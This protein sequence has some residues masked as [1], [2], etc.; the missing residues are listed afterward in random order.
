MLAH[1]KRPLLVVVAAL[2]VPA[3]AALVALR[4]NR[5]PSSSMEPSFATGSLLVSNRFAYA[6]GGA[7]ARGDAIVFFYPCQPGVEFAKR[8]V[9]VEGDVVSV[10]EAGFATVNGVRETA[11]RGEPWHE[12][13]PGCTPVRF[14]HDGYE[15]LHC[16]GED[17]TPLRDGEPLGWG[18]CDGN[19][20][21]FP[22][23]VPPGHV[24]VL[25][26][27]R[28]NSSD[29][30]HWGFVPVGHVLGRIVGSL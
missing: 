26:D 9:A 18:G 19:A 23:K 30:R 10:D 27:N 16:P 29:S 7:P 8:V 5:L 11:R 25:G 22:W 15:T 4:W 24:F 1:M 17:S 2:G 21:A 28:P 14:A 3:A 6:G 20:P 13:L 12:A